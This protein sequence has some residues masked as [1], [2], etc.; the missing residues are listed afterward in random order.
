M[1]RSGLTAARAQRKSATKA[2]HSSVAGSSACSACLLQGR[3][4]GCVKRSPTR[5][6]QTAPSTSRRTR[7]GS[8]DAAGR[9]AAHDDAS[10]RAIGPRVARVG[11]NPRTSTLISSRAEG[12]GRWP[13]HSNES[14]PRPKARPAPSHCIWDFRPLRPLSPSLTFSTARANVMFRSR[15]VA[16]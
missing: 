5:S 13:C 8:E 3:R 11:R 12:I 1:V 7:Q 2:R 14:S 4:R 15:P 9:T 10:R 6:P 16:R